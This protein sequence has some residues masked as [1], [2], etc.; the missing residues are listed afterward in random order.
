MLKRMRIVWRLR[1]CSFLPGGHRGTV[2]PR[3][4]EPHSVNVI[5]KQ[6]TAMGVKYLN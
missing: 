6:I 4:M 5:M 3:L 1:D 2:C